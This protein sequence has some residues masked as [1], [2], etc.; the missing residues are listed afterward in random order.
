M[1]HPGAGISTRNSDLIEGPKRRVR[2]APGVPPR[3]LLIALWVVAAVAASCRCSSK[4]VDKIDVHARFPAD[5]APRVI[6]LMNRQ[7][8]RAVVNL[9]GG[10]AGRG[11]E[12]QLKAAAAFPGRIIVFSG[13]DWSEPPKGPG[14]GARMAAGLA[15]AHQLGARGVE[16]PRGLG[17]GF[18]KEHG[19]LLRI[20]DPELDPVFEKAAE[21]GMPVMIATGAPIAF[22]LPAI[23]KNERYEELKAHPELSLYEQAPPWE[24]LFLA[25]E[26]RIARHPKCTFISG[27]FGNAAEHPERVAAML[28]KYP[29][30][31][32]DIA[33]RVPELGRHPADRMRSLINQRAD[34]ILFGTDLAFGSAPKDIVLSSRGAAPP[35]EKEVAHFFSATWRYLETDDKGFPHPTPIQGKWKIDGV[36]LSASD[37]R[38]IYS[39]NAARLLKL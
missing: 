17:I 8:I 1:A 4:N 11:L 35:D 25:L 2:P 20:D 14:Y 13:L 21:L 24:S 36:D 15:R 22:W 27:Y 23:A 19:D 16:I 12:E 30:L 38:K 7:G 18:R 29:N 3:G 39:G 33:G 9:G 34:R 26:R 28:D 37:L 10:V 5:A 6:E 32:I 31:Y